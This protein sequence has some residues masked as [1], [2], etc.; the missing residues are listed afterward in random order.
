LSTALVVAHRPSTVLLADR[1][2]LLSDGA[3]AAIG[4][5]RELL[6]N[7]P[8]YRELMSAAPDLTTGARR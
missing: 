8:R 2:A 1:V 7:E 3:I 4:T 6:D 5:H